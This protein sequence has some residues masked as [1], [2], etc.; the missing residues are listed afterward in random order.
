[1]KRSLL[2]VGAAVLLGAG[3]ANADF[4]VT[5]T[6]TA[7]TGALQGFD[8][9]KFFGQND[10][11]GGTA[12]S[13]KLQ[14]VSL[15]MSV[16]TGNLKLDFRD[17]DGDAVND[18]N[19]L[20][21]GVA[22]GSPTGTY[23][24][25][26]GIATFNAVLVEPGGGSSD[27]DGDGTANSDPSTDPKFTS[28]LK[29]IRVD[30]FQPPANAPAAGTAPGAQFAAAIVPTGNAVHMVGSIAGEAGSA[31]PVNYTDPG[32]NIPEPAS[33]SLVGLGALGF[34]GRRSRKA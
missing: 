25:P 29:S 3:V 23:I 33:L 19:I 28:Q 13:T 31:V 30:G 22:A 20:G 12:G 14:S 8:V 15:T 17:L 21:S 5:S 27:P 2:A 16:D 4:I 24:R 7:G 34:L 10:G 11:T 26:G 9:V 6:R 18:A 32:N 1:M